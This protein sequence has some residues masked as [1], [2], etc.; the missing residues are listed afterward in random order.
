MAIKEECG[1]FGIYS[2]EKRDVAWDV[3]CGLFSLQHRGQEAAGIAINEDRNI[4]CYKGLGL[5]HEVFTE[6][7]L[8][9]LGKGEI[10]VGHVRYATT[11]DGDVKNAQPMVVK[12]VKG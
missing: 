10:A 9:S 7:E 4:R 12:H 6:N 8:K 11:G 3:Y 1:V 5:V 2:G